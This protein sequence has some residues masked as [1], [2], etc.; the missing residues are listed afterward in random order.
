VALVVLF[1]WLYSGVEHSMGGWI[2]SYAQALRMAS[3][4]SAAYL[5]SAFWAALTAGRLLAVPLSARFRPEAI[6]AVALAG[7]LL[8]AVVVLLW[9]ESVWLL[10]LGTLG[11]GLSLAAIVPTTLALMGRR[12]GVTSRATAWYFVGLGAGTM[13]IPWTIG[14]FFEGSGP[15]SLFVVLGLVLVAAAGLFAAV[16]AVKTPSRA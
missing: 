14:Q 12:I 16:A 9:P 7:S 3:G 10:W 13:T 1:F 6:V 4:P 8:S 11:L 15:R 5:A 2:S